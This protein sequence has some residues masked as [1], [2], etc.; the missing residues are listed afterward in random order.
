MELYLQQAVEGIEALDEKPEGVELATLADT[1][2][3]LNPDQ[4]HAL[5][6][7]GTQTG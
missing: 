1:I 5:S 4:K 7:R 2:S 6:A 3:D